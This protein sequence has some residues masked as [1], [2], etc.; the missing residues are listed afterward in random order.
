MIKTHPLHLSVLCSALL[1]ASVLFSSSAFAAG[2]QVNGQS[3]TGLGRAFAGDAVI[4]D[5][6]SVMARNPAAMSLFDRPQ[7]SLGLINIETDVTVKGATYTTLLGSQ[8][9]ADTQIGGTSPVPN[10][11]YTHPVSDKLTLG[12]AIYSNFGTKTEFASDYTANQFGG[13]TDLKSFNVGISAAYKVTPQLS[14]GAGID[15][16]YGMGKLRRDPPPLVSSIMGIQHALSI[17]VSGSGIG[18]N[19]GAVYQVN[20]KHR[21]GLSY[22]YSPE[23]EASGDVI[24]LDKQVGDLIIPLPNIAEFSGFHQTTPRLALHYSLQW[25]DWSTFDTLTTTDGTTLS[26]YAWQDG[27]HISLGTTFTLDNNWTLRAGYMY[28]TS[29]QDQITSISVPDS[30]RQWFSAGVSYAFSPQSTFDFGVTYLMGEDVKVHE[31]MLGSLYQVDATTRANAL[32]YGVQ[33]SYKF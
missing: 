24:Y 27:W 14:L 13:L 7:L 17:D 33:Y 28:D 18:A 32:L 29:A 31:T 5:N 9:L 11:F 22:R 19:V 21:F 2:F 10:I 20:D 1:S 26:Q 15:F 12:G 16:I 23:I 3:A 30:D 4:A 8:Q 25:I 6:A